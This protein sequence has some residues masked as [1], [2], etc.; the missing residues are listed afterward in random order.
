MQ[1]G[2]IALSLLL[3]RPVTLHDFERG[4]AALLDEFTAL[5]ATSPSMFTAPLRGVARA[6]T[7]TG[8]CARIVRRETR[9]K[10]CT[11]CPCPPDRRPP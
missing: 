11:N 2:V 3:G 1:L 9:K 10:G 4:L 5:A 8:T 7:A 6:R